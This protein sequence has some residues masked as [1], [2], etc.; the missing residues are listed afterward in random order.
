M[1]SAITAAT[2]RT[3]Q[4][5][6]LVLIAAAATGPLALNIFVPSMPGIQHVFGVS[7]GVVQ[8]ALSLYLFAV[9]VAQLFIGSLSD[10]FGRRPVMVLGAALFLLGSVVCALAGNI[11]TLIVGRV[12]QAVG[13]CTGLVLGRAIARDIHDHEGATRMVAYITMAM[14]V[15]PMLGPAIG[16]YLDEWF[17]WRAS[18][19]LMGVLGVLVLGAAWRWAYETNFQRR[20]MPG[21]GAMLRGFGELLRSPCFVGY[22]S[23]A[24][25]TSGIFFTFLGGAPYVMVEILD[26][27]P[28]EYGLYFVL[29]SAGYMLGNFTAAKLSRRVGSTRMLAIAAILAMA[30]VSLMALLGIVG[31]RSPLALFGPMALATYSN[32]LGLPNAL[33]GAISVEPRQAGAASGLAGFL[34]MGLGALCTVVVGPLVASSQ[35]PMVAMMLACSVLAIASLML[36]LAG[37]R[38]GPATADGDAVG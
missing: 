28:S 38:R 24:A 31:M 18:F 21:L 19:L 3:R 30:A 9:A 23:N 25:F 16:G 27:P 5:P 11:V 35:L 33:V 2:V 36:A 4:P 10:R 12:V 34:Q 32:G 17:G 15:A 6:L 7:Y 8:L 20:P 13:G 14:V 1:S 22:A 29:I 26:R 37:G